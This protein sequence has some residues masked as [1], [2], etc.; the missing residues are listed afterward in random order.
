M[1]P[2]AA[3]HIWLYTAVTDMRKHFDGLAALVQSQLGIPA[4]KSIE[5]VAEQSRCAH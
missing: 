1:L 4:T 5:G 3:G 2:C